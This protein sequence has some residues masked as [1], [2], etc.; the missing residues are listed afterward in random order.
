VCQAPTGAF[1]LG[2]QPIADV[3]ELA[4]FR[5]LSVVGILAWVVVEPGGV[6]LLRVAFAVRDHDLTGV[7]VV[8]QDPFGWRV[9]DLIP[10]RRSGRAPMT[11]VPIRL[12]SRSRAWR[13][14]LG[15]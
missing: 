2:G 3:G 10:D 12:W 1:R 13:T 4:A 8:E 7:E 9:L 11:W 5:C 14:A 6:R 15:G